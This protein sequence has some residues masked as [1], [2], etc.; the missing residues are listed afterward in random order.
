ME[1]KKSPVAVWDEVP[2][3]EKLKMSEK[4]ASICSGGGKGDEGGI[5]PGRHCAGS[6]ICRGKNMEPK[7]LHPQLSV[8]FTVDTNAI[9]VTIR[10]SIGDLIAEV[11]AATKTFAPGGKHPRAATVYMTMHLEQ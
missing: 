11:G 4:Y 9:V 10:I 2:A 3:T 7:I 8:L 5:R 6:G 1:K